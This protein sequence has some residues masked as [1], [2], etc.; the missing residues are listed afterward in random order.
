MGSKGNL[1]RGIRGNAMSKRSD[2]RRSARG[3]AATR[4][5]RHAGR[6]N[7]ARTAPGIPMDPNPQETQAP[8]TELWRDAGSLVAI[9]RRHA[10]LA[11]ASPAE[12]RASQLAACR[13][14]WI[15]YAAAF[16]S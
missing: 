14:V 9:C 7:Q 5:H 8:H 2:R 3:G 4:P 12:T 15:N 1:R 6:E 10:D 13:L 16:N 11:L